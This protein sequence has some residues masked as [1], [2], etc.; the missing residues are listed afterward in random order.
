MRLVPF[1]LL[2]GAC[3]TKRVET[4]SHPTTLHVRLAISCD[5]I[6]ERHLGAGE[7]EPVIVAEGT[8][9]IDVPGMH[10]GYSERNGKHSNVHD[11]D[12]YE[13]IRVRREDKILIGLSLKDIRALPKASDGRSLVTCGL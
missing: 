3:L 2:L 8:A 6:L 13:V 11:P 7:F 12:T 1:V 9:D 4:M 10:G 5:G